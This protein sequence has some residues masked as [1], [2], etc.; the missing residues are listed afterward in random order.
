[1]L[2]RKVTEHVNDQNWFAVGLDFLIVV[3]GVLF[4]FQ[5]TEWDKGRTLK[6]EQVTATQDL[7]GESV[8]IVRYL[9]NIIAEN[10]YMNELREKAV[11]SLVSGDRSSLNDGQLIGGLTSVFV[12]PAISPP[13]DVYDGIASS[14]NLDLIADR[15]ARRAVSRYYASLTGV[16]S[17]L[18]YWRNF[19]TTRYAYD[20]KGIS[21]IY[22][23]SSPQRMDIE[24][25][26]ESLASDPDFV[27]GRIELLRHQV[28]FQRFRHDLLEDAK[29][30]CRDLAEASG[31]P[32]VALEEKETSKAHSE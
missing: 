7:L 17:Q 6:S 26:F 21:S 9:E 30:M 23:P 8:E 27:E 24:V 10:D 19:V 29:E 31:L 16:Q 18:D 13:R 3:V 11:Q 32:C 2:L 22:D 25:N 1:M 4:A 20:H 12:Y 28:Q 5:I 15:G 14:G